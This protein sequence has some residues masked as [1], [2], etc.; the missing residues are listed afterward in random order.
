MRVEM[1][2]DPERGWGVIHEIEDTTDEAFVEETDEL[3][4]S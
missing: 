2:P 1:P 3:D 4:E